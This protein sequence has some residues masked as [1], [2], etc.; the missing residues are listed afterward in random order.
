MALMPLAPTCSSRT[1]TG[2]SHGSTARLKAPSMC[3]VPT[4]TCVLAGARAAPARSA[5]HCGSRLVLARHQRQNAQRAARAIDNLE[6]RRNHYRAGRRQ[7]IEIRKTC[8]PESVGAVHDGMA[9]KHGI[10]GR[11]LTRIGADGFD[12]DPENIALPRQKR[13]ALGMEARRMRAVRPDIQELIARALRPFGADQYPSA[14]RN[15]AVPALPLFHDALREQKIG[16]LAHLPRDVDD[17]CGAD[18]AL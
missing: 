17:A 10:E 11:R 15:A 13:H 9:G 5:G 6:R 2:A 4:C 14:A 18:E 8:E 12:T 1:G 7:L 3:C 16:I